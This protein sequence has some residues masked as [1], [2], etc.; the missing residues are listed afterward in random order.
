MLI[1]IIAIY[2]VVLSYFGIST[3][4]K[5]F[6][7]LIEY[8][9]QQVDPKF[10][11][12]ART[13]YHS[14]NRT[15]IIIGSFT[16]FPIKFF[17]HANFLIGALIFALLISYTRGMM[18]SLLIKMMFLYFNFY[19]KIMNSVSLTIE[20]DFTDYKITTPIVISNHSCWFDTFYLTLRFSPL[21]FVAKYPIK[22]WPV[23]GPIAQ[24]MSCI[25]VKRESK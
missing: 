15:L 25:F 23:I 4:L 24:A 22:N 16:M 19:G 11:G 18:K 17:A 5:T 10:Y 3:N 6:K 14:W 7:K 12:V 2:W 1:W 8:S 9:K 21:S 13:D 20:D